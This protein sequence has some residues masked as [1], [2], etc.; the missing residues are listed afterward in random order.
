MFDVLL[1]IYYALVVIGC[2]AQ[3]SP[4]QQTKLYEKEDEF[5][6][7]NITVKY[8]GVNP[9]L[10]EHK[11]DAFDYVTSIGGYAKVLKSLSA[12][13]FDTSIQVSI[14]A[15]DEGSFETVVSTTVQLVGLVGSICGI[16]SFF[17]IDADDVLGAL[18]GIQRALVEEIKNA[19]GNID[20]IVNRIVHSEELDDDEK[21]KLIDAIYNSGFREGLDDFTR[22]LDGN[23]YYSIQVSRHSDENFSISN[24]ERMYF[25]YVP[26]AEEHTEPFDDQVEI[27]YLSP[28]LNRWQFQG[29]IEFW[30]DVLDVDFIRLT[31]DKK[32]SELEGVKFNAFGRKIITRKAGQKKR[33][34]T[35]VIDSIKEAPTHMKLPYLSDS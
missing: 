11:I 19:K 27:V 20:L 3:R 23:G 5:C 26:P 34:N 24:K 4:M 35:W 15:E 14:V 6:S 29:R 21:N 31:K 22:P 12:D 30:A 2:T 33:T 28:H 10:I 9:L 25:K 16:L 17:K 8:D 7:E 13:L 18:S 32:P 1:N